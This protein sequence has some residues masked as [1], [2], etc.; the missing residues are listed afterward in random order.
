MSYAESPFAQWFM[1]AGLTSPEAEPVQGGRDLDILPLADGR[2]VWAQ[3]YG[4]TPCASVYKGTEGVL[5][6][7]HVHFEDDYTIESYLPTLEGPVLRT[8]ADQDGSLLEGPTE[9]SPERQLEIIELLE[10]YYFPQQQ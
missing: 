5:L 7:G 6:T 10:P 9:V 8:V 1:R 2:V 4:E 3:F